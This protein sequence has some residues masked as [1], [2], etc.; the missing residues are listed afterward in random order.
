MKRNKMIVALLLAFCLAFTM[1]GCGGG[2]T[3]ESGQQGEMTWQ[4]QYWYC[5]GLDA[6]EELTPDDVCETDAIDAW[7][8]FVADVVAYWD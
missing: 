1:V 4:G 6:D 3:N 7:D 8:M 2:A 5:E